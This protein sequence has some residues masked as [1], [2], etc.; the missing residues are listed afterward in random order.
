MNNPSLLIICL[1]QAVKRPGCMG[2]AVTNGVQQTAKTM[3]VTYRWARVL[4]VVLDGMGQLVT[5]V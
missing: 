4:D 2:I 1:F 5:Q 3:Y